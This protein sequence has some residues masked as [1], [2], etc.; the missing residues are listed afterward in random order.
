MSQPQERAGAWGIL[1]AQSVPAKKDPDNSP[2]RTSRRLV[3]ILAL[4]M[5]SEHSEAPVERGR[6]DPR[7]ALLSGLGTALPEQ[8]RTEKRQGGGLLKR[9]WWYTTPLVCKCLSLPGASRILW[10]VASSVCCLP[11]PRNAHCVQSP[12]YIR[13]PGG[14]KEAER[15]LPHFGELDI[16]WALGWQSGQNMPL[17]VKNGGCGP[18]PSSRISCVTLGSLLIFSASVSWCVG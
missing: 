5:S 10:L 13:Y 12:C 14:T 18:A 8:V 11:R 15:R 1:L 2:S 9:L 3:P 6:G 16:N 17:I 4:F 7:D